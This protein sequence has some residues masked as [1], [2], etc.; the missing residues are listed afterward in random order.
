MSLFT[1]QPT[2]TEVLGSEVVAPPNE[3][4]D[5]ASQSGSSGVVSP[6]HSPRAGESREMATLRRFLG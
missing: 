4:S 6:Y 5:F 1:L 3:T 2:K